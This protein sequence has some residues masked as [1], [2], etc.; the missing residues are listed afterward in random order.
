MP[1]F[2][3]MD[4]NVTL[5]AQM[6]EPVGQVI[7]INKF[8]VEPGDIDQFLKAWAADGAVMK[9]QPG[10]VSAQLHRGI[11]GSS[12]FVNCAAWESSQHFKR[13]F[14]NPEFQSQLANY[15]ASVVGSPHLFKKIAVPGICVE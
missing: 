2:V 15:P 7:L 1:K 9:R 10:F 4:E 13:A 11:G 12:V 5:F 3:E 14:Q 6:E 8:N